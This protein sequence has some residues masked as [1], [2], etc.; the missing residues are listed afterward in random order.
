MSTNPNQLSIILG[1]INITG[2]GE[3]DIEMAY[4]TEDDVSEYVGMQGEHSFTENLDESGTLKITIK[5]IGL[6]V[7]IMNNVLFIFDYY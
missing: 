5:N 4:N 2:L 6:T 3:D 1:G 7:F